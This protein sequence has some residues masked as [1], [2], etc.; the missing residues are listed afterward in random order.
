MTLTFYLAFSDIFASFFGGGGRSRRSGPPKTAPIQKTLSV[1]L[2]TFYH[3]DVIHYPFARKKNCENCKGYGSTK[4]SQCPKCKGA[5]V[6]AETRS[7]AP[8]FI[9]QVHTTCSR[10]S[11]SGI[12][13][14]MS[15]SCTPCGARGQLNSQNSVNVV[16]APGMPDDTMVFEGEGNEE[17]NE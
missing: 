10:C 2:E 12:I 16:I 15:H 7:L 1:K 11:G 8:G 13:K 6:V 14:D 3:G 5:G 9:Q 4:T 17:V